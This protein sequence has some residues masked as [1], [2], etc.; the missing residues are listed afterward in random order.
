MLAQK[1]GSTCH[2]F[3]A[4]RGQKAAS[5]L[6]ELERQVVAS[7]HVGTEASLDPLQQKQILLRTEL[8]L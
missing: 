4:H 6:L 5:E 2:A 8:S 1:Y 7:H 3:G